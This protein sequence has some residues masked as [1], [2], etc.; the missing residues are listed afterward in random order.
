MKVFKFGGASIKDAASVK[1]VANILR[2]NLHEPLVVVISAMD[3]MTNA[4]ELL[5]DHAF[6][7]RMKEA[8]EQLN[9]IR[10]FHLNILNELFQDTS[11]AIFKK[12]DVLFEEITG[13]TALKEKGSFNAFYDLLVPYGELLSTSI[14]SACLK[15]SGF[16]HTLADA[17]T[18]ILTDNN[19]RNA[20][21][22]WEDTITS[23]NKKILPLISGNSQPYHFVLSQGFIGSDP[24]GHSTTLGREGSDYTAAILA[25]ALNADEVLIWKDVPG[26]MNADPKIF[27]ESVK[28]DKLSYS[29]AIELAYYGAKIIHPK[30]IKP[31]QNK[32]IPLIVKSFE[33]PANTGTY[34]SESEERYETVP[35]YIFKFN[36]IL[37]SLTPRDF[38][39]INEENLFDIFGIFTKYR[40]HIN[41]MQN[42]AI[43][44]SVC[45]DDK[46]DFGSFIT[47][48]QEN[49][50]VKYNRGLELITI[51]NYNELNIENVVNKRVILLE[52][53]SRAT[54][55]L[56]VASETD[57]YLQG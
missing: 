35:Q 6:A 48:L 49:Y 31:L 50:R 11:H 28:I 16:E 34:I 41:L 23:V 46:A 21:V 3:K 56:V 18:F 26:L 47:A 45:I 54:V 32:D 25:F 55:Q 51:R 42:S 52:Q 1:N 39:F 22:I 40:V 20:R 30:T 36:Q 4:F 13:I 57:N 15:I 7:N 2:D 38:S 24:D 29:D 37:I 53:R 43:S 19:Y 33:N 10:D 27:P 5:A 14:T 9:R 17:R 44:F 8:E 12:V